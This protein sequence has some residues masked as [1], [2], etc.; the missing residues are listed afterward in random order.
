MKLLETIGKALS[1]PAA[2]LRRALV[3]RHARKQLELEEEARKVF[4]EHQAQYEKAL[5]N[6]GRKPQI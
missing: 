4:E 3:K 6:V 2:A 1:W 5:E